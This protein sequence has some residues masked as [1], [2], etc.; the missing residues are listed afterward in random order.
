MIKIR[1]QGNE[2]E[3]LKA[4]K[5]LE[6]VMEIIEV[7]RPYQDR[8]PSQYCRIYVDAEIIK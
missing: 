8:T 5:D 1:L 3:L 6:Q 2:E 4:I 7:S